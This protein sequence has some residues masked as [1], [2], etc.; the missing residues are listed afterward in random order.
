[1]VQA[2][3]SENGKTITVVKGQ[4]LKLTLG[5]PGD[6]GYAFDTPKYNSA[7]LSLTDH[8]HIA[9]T[10]GAIGDAGKDTWEFKALK[11]GRSTLSISATRSFDKANPVIMFSGTVVVN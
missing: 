9:S 3:Y 1:V 6:G 8:T 5:N 10:S 2:D 11:N 4:T 7:V